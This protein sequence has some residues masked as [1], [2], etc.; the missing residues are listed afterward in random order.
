[1]TSK[2]QNRVEG[3]IDDLKGRSKVAVGELIDNE[4]IKQSGREDQAK[5]QVKKA[6]A[7]VKDKIDDIAEKVTER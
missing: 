7:D 2:T 1:M 4:D 6:T 5:G 3:A